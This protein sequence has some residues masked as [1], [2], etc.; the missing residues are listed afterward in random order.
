MPHWA[1]ARFGRLEPI[2]GAA[3]EGRPGS[4]RF[5]VRYTMAIDQRHTTRHLEGQGADEYHYDVA[6]GP[7]WRRGAAGV[8]D[9][10]C[11]GQTPRR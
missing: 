3:I 11:L 8:I 9:L 4:G 10:R 2:A 5:A 6:S 7:G 1:S